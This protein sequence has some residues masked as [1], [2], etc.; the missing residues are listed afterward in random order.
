MAGFAF[1]TMTLPILVLVGFWACG[2]WMNSK[3][4]KD[5][6]Q[7][8]KRKKA[9]DQ[10]RKNYDPRA[11]DNPRERARQQSRVEVQREESRVRRDT[12]KV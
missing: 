12:K 10:A 11:D 9:Y 8:A 6:E 3:E 7:R 1:L 4:R 5:R 2:L